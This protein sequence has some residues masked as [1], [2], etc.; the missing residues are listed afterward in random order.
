MINDEDI[1]GCG[2]W[3]QVEAKLILESFLK[4]RSRRVSLLTG[5]IARAI[6]IRRPFKAEIK[7]PVKTGPIEQRPVHF[8]GPVIQ[9]ACNGVYSHHPSARAHSADG[10]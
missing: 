9:F 5:A 3:F 7:G 1:D 8:Q 10:A 6:H 4:R 2:Y